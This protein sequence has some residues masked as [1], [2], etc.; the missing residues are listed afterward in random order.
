M[1]IAFASFSRSKY[2]V[3]VIITVHGASARKEKRADV[4]EKDIYFDI[5]LAVTL[6][7]S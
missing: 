5:S 4:P 7:L 3:F 1:I 2:S 6:M